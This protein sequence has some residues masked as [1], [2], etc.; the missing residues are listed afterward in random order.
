MGTNRVLTADEWV[1]QCAA[2]VRQ[3]VPAMQPDDAKTHAENLRRAW[4]ALPPEDAVACYFNDTHFEE[5]EWSVFEI[6][7]PT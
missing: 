1:E 2:L 6:P 7:K 5:T 4:P 3:R